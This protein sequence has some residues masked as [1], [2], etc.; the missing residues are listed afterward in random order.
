MVQKLADHGSLFLSLD[1][2]RVPLGVVYHKVDRPQVAGG[3]LVLFVGGPL[4]RDDFLGLVVDRW[5]EGQVSLAPRPVPGWLSGIHVGDPSGLGL[6]S[7][8]FQA[9]FLPLPAFAQLPLL[10]LLLPVQLFLPHLLQACFFLLSVLLSPFVYGHLLF[11]LWRLGYCGILR[12]R[13]FSTHH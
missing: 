7:S 13:L 11:F 5:L 12:C 3:L 10:L 2:V 9:S 4:V 8:P 1:E 6:L